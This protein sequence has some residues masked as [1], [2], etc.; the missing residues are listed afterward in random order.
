MKTTTITDDHTALLNG[1]FG[2]VNQVITLDDGSELVEIHIADASEDWECGEWYLDNKRI[3]LCDGYDG[4]S[5]DDGF[6]P[7]EE[8]EDL[9]ASYEISGLLDEAKAA[10]TTKP[11]KA[12]N[13]DYNEYWN[14]YGDARIG[15][16]TAEGATGNSDE[17]ISRCLSG[18]VCADLLIATATAARDHG[19]FRWESPRTG[20]LDNI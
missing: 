8:I 14:Q 17:E 7:T 12:M 6:E 20:M 18:R 15:R 5:W 19:L 11:T 13:E 1:Y 9:V 4:V 3:A 2:H 10:T 16:M